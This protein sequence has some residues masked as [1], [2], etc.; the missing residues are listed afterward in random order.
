MANMICSNI[1]LKDTVDKQEELRNDEGDSP[2]QHELELHYINWYRVCQFV[3]YV[4]Y[5]GASLQNH[6][7]LKCWVAG[8]IGLVWDVNKDTVRFPYRAALGAHPARD[9]SM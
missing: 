7:D 6:L 1:R 4:D 8:Q 9:G 3:K 5:N 2:G